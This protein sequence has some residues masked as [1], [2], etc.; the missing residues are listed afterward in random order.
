MMNFTAGW[1]DY[2]T[3]ANYRLQ[4]KI[5]FGS[6][7]P[8]V[9]VEFAVKRYT[10]LLRPEV[11]EKIFYR[12]AVSFLKLEDDSVRSRKDCSRSPHDGSTEKTRH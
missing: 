2:V 7:Y 12:N 9:P 5:L 3:A 8:S 6:L 11:R 4:D 10:A 1:Q